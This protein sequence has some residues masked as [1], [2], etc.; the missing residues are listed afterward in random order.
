MVRP[1]TPIGH[2]GVI[3]AKKLDSGRW[4]ARTYFRDQ[5]GMRRDVTARERSKGAAVRKLQVKLESLPALGVGRFSSSSRLG[6]VLDW[7]LDR[8][9]GAEQ[10]RYNLGVSVRAL[11]RN[12]GHFQLFELSVPVVVDYLESVK[13]ES[14]A[15]RQRQ[16]LRAALGEMVRLGVLASN[17]VE[18]TRPRRTARKIPKALTPAEA[19]EVIRIVRERA[20]GDGVAWLGDLCELLAAT[21]TR[22]GE[23]AGVR[24]VDVDFQTGRLIV[25]GTVITGG[26]YQAHT[27][28]HQVRVVR[29]PAGVLDMLRRRQ[30]SSESEFIFITGRG[31]LLSGSSAGNALRRCLKGTRFEWV[32]LHT[33]RRSVAT[34]L[35]REVGM[36]AAALQ[37]GH[38]Q[39]S[40]TRKS[41]V[42][43]R[44]EAD[45]SEFLECS[46]Y[47]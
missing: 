17:P 8:W 21:G 42:E 16:V 41:Y 18:A 6:E 36:S 19:L 11:K 29:L 1:Q 47:A 22:F 33:F 2:H 9:E 7:W 15:R 14:S 26:A 12:L 3:T 25:R 35:E 39:E 37:L 4:V 28:T 13:A 27:K 46:L 32:T 23:A 38:E 30:E 43:R 45:F 5:R 24:W 10:T 40:T 44:G 20:G 34:W 31:N